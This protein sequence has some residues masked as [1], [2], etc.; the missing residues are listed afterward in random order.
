MRHRIIPVF[1]PHASCPNQ[2]IFCNQKEITRV[3][4]YDHQGIKDILTKSVPFLSES[5]AT[6]EIAFYGG[7]FTAIEAGEQEALLSIAK[8]YIDG[9]GVD[10]IRVSTRPDCIDDDIL[11][12]LK[13]F[14]VKTIELGVQSMSDDVLIANHRG[15][16]KAD[17][18]NASKMIKDAG[19]T[20]GHQIMPGLY[21]DS[22]ETINET[23]YESM[24]LR[25]DIM[26]VYPCV[27]VKGTRLHELYESGEY[28][29]LTLD[30]A[31]EICKKVY[32]KARENGIRIIRMGLHPDREFIDDALVAGPF[33]PA[34]K[35]L[36]IS[37]HYY[38][39]L[40]ATIEEA[41]KLNASAVDDITFIVNPREVSSFVGMNRDNVRRLQEKFSIN[42]IKFT[43]DE[44]VE[45]GTFRRAS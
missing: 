11:M 27:V 13:R 41:N 29:P 44:G 19:F 4:G 31:V 16:T 9:G 21:K 43:T 38:S 8:R 26:R 25:P 3:R 6:R 17:S 23:I 12:R 40:E 24:K 20:L 34:F 37:S 22:D 33:H 35:H 10:S 14:G 5:S 18:V 45:E 7:S 28:V 32:L 30:K 15:H 2:C 36:V 39:L 42:S 1:I